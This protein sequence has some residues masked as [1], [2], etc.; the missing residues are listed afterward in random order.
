MNLAEK[1]TNHIQQQQLFTQNDL[2]IIGVSG[3]ID[4]VALC[5]LLKNSGYQFIIYHANFQLRGP[6]SNRDEDFVQALATDLK[7]ELIVERFDTKE[8]ALNNKISIQEAARQLRY[9]GFEKTRNEKNAAFIL[10]AHNANDNAETLIINLL[11]S[12]GIA[13]A[14]AI[15]LKE[16]KIRRP[17]LAF[18]RKDIETYMQVYG[19]TW[20]EDSSNEKDVYVR[21][22]I[23]HKIIPEL[24]AINPNAVEAFNTSIYHFK[25]TEIIYNYWIETTKQKLI[26]KKKNEWHIPVLKLKKT[27]PL[28]TIVYEI[29]KDFNFTAA[30]TDEVITLFE[31]ESGKYISNNKYRILKNRSWLIIS[32]VTEVD[33]SLYLIEDYGTVTTSNGR[34]TINSTANMRLDI[35]GIK[36]NK[37]PNQAFIN[38]DDIQFPL[39]LRKCK[40][41][42]YFYP[43]G[44]KK[45]KKLS[46]FFI[47]QKLSKPDKENVWVLEANKKIVW[48]IGQRIDDRFKLTD[49]TESIVLLEWG[50]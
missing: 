3:G 15:P 48:V 32:A 22:K 50:A 9:E 37:N 10:T 24:E 40:T 46:R 20:V 28:K 41:G 19:Y 4:S 47:D 43:L 13:G 39:L 5:H 8:Y 25:E 36:A 23:R 26:E 34:L 29:I 17:L 12:T 18:T 14:T 16:N 30:Q 11:R 35:N 7:V 6:E 49:N 1:F 44:M 27:Q 33:N 21:N 2:L 45:K 42:D 31:S 38:F